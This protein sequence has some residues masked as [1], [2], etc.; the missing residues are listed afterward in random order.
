MYMMQLWELNVHFYDG[1]GK[2]TIN[3]STGMYS[4]LYPKIEKEELKDVFN[5]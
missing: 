5:L 2:T 3:S 4:E 1:L